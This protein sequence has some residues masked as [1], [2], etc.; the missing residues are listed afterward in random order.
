VFHCFLLAYTPAK[1]RLHSH[2]IYRSGRVALGYEVRDERSHRRSVDEINKNE[3]RNQLRL[4]LL[5]GEQLETKR[6]DNTVCA[7]LI[8]ASF[9]TERCKSL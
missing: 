7:V 3:I 1:L 9:S 4:C 2:K 8:E 6:D 5:K